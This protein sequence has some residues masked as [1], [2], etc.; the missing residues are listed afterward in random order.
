MGEGLSGR[1]GC[2][3]D[4][5]AIKGRVVGV[6]K[7]EVWSVVLSS[8]KFSAILMLLGVEPW[9]QMLPWLLQGPWFIIWSR[10]WSYSSMKVTRMGLRKYSLPGF[11]PEV[12]ALGPLRVGTNDVDETPCNEALM[13]LMN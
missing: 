12:V 6:T 8:P 7:E 9:S 11:W 3:G 13:P 5:C 1:N 4:D 2:Q 10:L